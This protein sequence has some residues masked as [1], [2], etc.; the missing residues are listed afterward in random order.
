MIDTDTARPSTAS[1][2]GEALSQTSRLVAAEIQLVRIE[3]T[4]KLSTAV[5][6]VVGIVIAAVFMIVAMIFLLQGVVA[7][8]VA[9]GLAVSTANFAVGGAI[10]VLA[11]VAIFIALRSL[12]S[13]KLKPS[14]TLRQ[15]H[16]NTELMKGGTR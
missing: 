14:R 1:L 11:A 2:L 16:E 7:L 8:L 3:I 12:S 10:A 4:D 15:M 9:F 5:K 6:A 13:S